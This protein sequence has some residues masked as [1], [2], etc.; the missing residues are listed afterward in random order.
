MVPKDNCSAISSM[1][2]GG[3]L[4]KE[5]SYGSEPNVVRLGTSEGKYGLVFECHLLGIIGW[6]TCSCGA[7][8]IMISPASNRLL[9][10]DLDCPVLRCS[11][12]DQKGSTWAYNFQT[13]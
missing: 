1:I 9:C 13:R 6:T 10:E 4:S 8:F 2:S 11:K 5:S 12:F 3:K 7:G